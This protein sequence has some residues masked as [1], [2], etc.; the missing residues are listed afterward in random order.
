MQHCKAPNRRA[1]AN[2]PANYGGAPKR[3]GKVAGMLASL[4]G[5]IFRWVDWIYAGITQS[6]SV[7]TFTFYCGAAV[8]FLVAIY[9]LFYY[10][11]GIFVFAVTLVMNVFELLYMLLRLSSYMLADLPTTAT[12]ITTGSFTSVKFYDELI[13][14]TGN[15]MNKAVKPSTAVALSTSIN[16][17]VDKAARAT[18]FMPVS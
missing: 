7:V 18:N 4:L 3:A 10:F 1:V 17:L 2:R 6:V 14:L 8:V 11:S 13:K 5:Q 9:N 12:T 16:L 15:A